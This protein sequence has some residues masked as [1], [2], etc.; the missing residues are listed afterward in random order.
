M[1]KRDWQHY[2]ERQRS[3]GRGRRRAEPRNAR[4]AIDRLIEDE[5]GRRG[6]KPPLEKEARGAA[7]R[8]ESAS[9]RR[10]DLTALPT[11]T[12]DPATARDFDDAVSAE[13]DGDGTR[14]WIHI[15]DVAAHVPPGSLLDRE[16]RGR[17]NS[18]YAPGAV[19]PMLPHAL[20][21]DACSLAPGVERLA[22]TA[23]IELSATG[24]PGRASFYRSRIRSDARLDY[25]RL[26]L[27]FSGRETAPAAV[28]EP[29][30]VARAA[31]AALGERRGSTR[32][33]DD[34]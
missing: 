7:D 10:R 9:G 25:D 23:E 30:A 22:V 26:D 14:L 27:I 17:A 18:T 3:R 31:A 11:F 24:E 16:A 8:A 21:S 6:F 28:A 33:D 4:A 1:S 15:A 12:V 2:R 13:R 20:S 34:A 29:L 5:L 19:E 32:R